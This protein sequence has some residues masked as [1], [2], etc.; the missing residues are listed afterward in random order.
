[1][2]Q[3][4]DAICKWSFYF[5]IKKKEL[6]FLQMVVRVHLLPRGLGCTYLQIEKAIYSLKNKKLKMAMY[7]W[8][9]KN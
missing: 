9:N 1:M 3:E 2:S 5:L 4:P 6:M 7:N 8:K